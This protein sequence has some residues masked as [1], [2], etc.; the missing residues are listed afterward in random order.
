IDM[1]YSMLPNEI[2]G[3]WGIRLDR[4]AGNATHVTYEVKRSMDKTRF[5]NLLVML[6][7]QDASSISG[8]DADLGVCV[9]KLQ[10]FSD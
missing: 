5:D 2:D 9:E 4:T 3:L 8:V 7:G 1:R 10:P 6:K